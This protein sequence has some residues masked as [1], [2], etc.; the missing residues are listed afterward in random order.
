MGV[1]SFGSDGKL[2]E[3]LRNNRDRAAALNE[4]MGNPDIKF[5][6]KYKTESC[7]LVIYGEILD[8]LKLGW[9]DGRPVDEMGASEYDYEVEMYKDAA[10]RGSYTAMAYSEVVPGGEMG[11]VHVSQMVL[12]SDEAFNL[13]MRKMEWGKQLKIV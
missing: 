5:G 7:N 8:G 13:Q 12:I 2:Q 6:Q 11:Q 1:F 4:E 10:S 3:Y 9:A